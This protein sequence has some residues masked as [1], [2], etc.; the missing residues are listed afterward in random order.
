[1]AI[2]LRIPGQTE[3]T[4]ATAT[5]GGSPGAGTAPV[6]NL[7]DDV[8]VVHAFSLSPTARAAGAVAPQDVVVEDDDILEIEVD[9]FTHVDLG[10]TIPRRRFAAFRP[11]AVQDGAIVVDALPAP[12]GA[13]RGVRRVARKRRPSA[14]PRRRPRSR[15]SSRI[16]RSSR[17]SPK[18]SASSSSTQAGSWATAKALTWLIERQ[19]RPREG[20][21]TWAQCDSRAAG[22]GAG[23]R[24]RHVRRLRRP[25][26]DPPVPARHRIEHA[27]QLRRVPRSRGERTS[28]TS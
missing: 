24:A 4:V 25:P 17:S 23:S 5:R 20:L 11:E 28:G 13:E 19:L 10:R 14:A 3:T 9:G 8:E 12:A 2:T 26:A 18:T 27:R 1:M 22:A 7:L 21:Y 15:T 16:R 6:T